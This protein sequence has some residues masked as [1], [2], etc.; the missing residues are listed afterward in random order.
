MIGGW[1]NEHS[2]GMFRAGTAAEYAG[3]TSLH[4]L[5]KTDGLFAY[6]VKNFG[7]FDAVTQRV[8]YLTALAL[9]DAGIGYERDR[10]L[11]I[12]LLATDVHGCAEPNKTYFKD[13][14]DGGRTLSRA[15][16]FIYTL[17][18]SPIAEAAV[19]FGLQGPLLYLRNQTTSVD[20]HLAT[21][22]RMVAEGQAACMLIYELTGQT[23]RCCVVGLDS[24]QFA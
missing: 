7:R 6:P 2:Y 17:P 19:H 14:V 21:A 16:L 5:G 13:Y 11:N 9:R 3:R 4:D 1:I 10:V 22:R 24:N 15:N 20:G 18:S 12:G 8:C 23:D